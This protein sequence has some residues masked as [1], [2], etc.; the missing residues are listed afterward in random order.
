MIA[1]ILS[2]CCVAPLLIASALA[3]DPSASSADPAIAPASDP[4]IDG[5]HA[6]KRLFGILPNYRASDASATYA[7]PTLKE[8][9]N[10]AKQNTFDWPNYFLNAGFAIQNQVAQNGFTGPGF[11]K[12]FAEYYA[13][14]WADNMIGNYTTQAFLPSI[15]GEDPRYYRMGEGPMLKRTWHA[16]SQVA[17]TKGTNGRNR[18]HLSELA[19]NAGVV[20]VTS[21]YYPSDNN[22]FGSSAT[23]WGLTL[24]NDAMANLLTEFLPDI[25]RK[26]RRKH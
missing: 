17:I 1:R 4:A 3:A 6:P 5:A 8:K 18:V 11:G 20:A 16:V 2:F 24:G 21:L 25:S 14:A 12:T 22:G 7:H 9:F 26:L 15:L 10:I 19:G 23:R 13:R